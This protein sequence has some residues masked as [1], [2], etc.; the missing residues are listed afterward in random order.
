[1]IKERKGIHVLCTLLVTSPK[2]KT[3]RCGEFRF[4]DSSQRQIQGISLP[5]WT[6]MD[7]VWDSSRFS[8]TW[9]HTGLPTARMLKT[10]LCRQNQEASYNQKMRN[11]RGRGVGGGVAT[12][13][14][15]SFSKQ[16]R[17]CYDGLGKTSSGHRAFKSELH[18]V[19]TGYR[20]DKWDFTSQVK[21]RPQP[22][23]YACFSWDHLSSRQPA[24][25][26][27]R[28]PT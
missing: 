6:W 28:G 27:S 21:P 18:R 4:S 23:K 12:F 15:I 11:C 10:V 13:R 25:R 7:I 5:I 3:T 9:G 19:G 8:H 26:T 24:E 1:M 14:A 17:G 2:S 22:A 20:T 16:S